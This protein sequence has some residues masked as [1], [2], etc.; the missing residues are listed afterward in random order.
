MLRVR[1]LVRVRVRLRLRVRVR[2]RVRVH[3]RMRLIV[4]VCVCLT[5]GEGGSMCVFVC[6]YINGIRP[7]VYYCASDIKC[8]SL[9]AMSLVKLII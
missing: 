7:N 9:P 8:V 3:V 5:D 6:L 2:V 1:V 4:R